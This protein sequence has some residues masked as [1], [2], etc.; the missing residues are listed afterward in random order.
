MSPLYYSERYVLRRDEDNYRWRIAIQLENMPKHT[1]D[2]LLK[3]NI[4]KYINFSSAKRLSP[5][6]WR[7]C[8]ESDCKEI[9]EITNEDI[10]TA[11]YNS[12]LFEEKK[13]NDKMIMLQTQLKEFNEEFDEISKSYFACIS[14]IDEKIKNAP[15]K[16]EK[17]NNLNNEIEILEKLIQD[18]K[19]ELSQLKE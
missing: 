14:E 13:H 16:V 6:I 18:R 10:K 3:E 2:H 7:T 12:F 5:G 4:L 15:L 1:V 11:L 9:I 8:E 19:N 17:I